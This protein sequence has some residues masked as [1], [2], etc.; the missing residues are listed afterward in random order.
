MEHEFTRLVP[1]DTSEAERGQATTYRPG[2]VI[3]FHQNAKGGFTRGERITVTD[4]AAVP[5]EH[6]S[7]FSLYRPE[8]IT[9][10]EG[11]RIRF[12]GR[13]KTLDG[14]HTLINGSAHAIAGFTPGGN[15]K[16]DNGRIVGKD[17]GHL[18]HGFV[19][20]SFGA[21]GRTVQRVLLGM[22]SSSQGAIN[23]EQLYVSA[24][25]AKEWIRLY[26]D[27]KDDIR[28][29]AQR[30]SQKLAALDIKRPEPQPVP[31]AAK[32]KRWHR[33]RQHMDRLRRLAVIDRTRAGAEKARPQPQ[34]ER[35]NERQA[36][37]GYGR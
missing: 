37:H 34:K 32:P 14:K 1:V 4:P 20:T 15:L 17:A 25:R 10:A 33:V 22:A 7:K 18:R 6:A 29:A 13:V 27:S 26:T 12:T 35:Q 11:D 24:S 9:L 21:Q 3:Q 28:Y 2:D 23:M 36:D 16:L 31:A 5:L 30:S 19:E 8:T